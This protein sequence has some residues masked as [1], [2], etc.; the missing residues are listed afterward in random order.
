MYQLHRIA[1]PFCECFG[2]IAGKPFFEEKAFP[3]TPSKKLSYKCFLDFFAIQD[4]FYKLV[5][6]VGKLE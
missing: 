4:G 5:T 1:P 2:K 3:H 6:L